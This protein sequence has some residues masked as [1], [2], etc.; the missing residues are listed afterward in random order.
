M[1]TP[2][3]ERA[4]RRRERRMAFPDRSR[5][6]PASRREPL[7]QQEPTTPPRP[8]VRIDPAGHAMIRIPHFRESE[9]RGWFPTDNG[10]WWRWGGEWW[11]FIEVP[12]PSQ[13]SWSWED[14]GQSTMERAELGLWLG[15]SSR[16]YW[17]G[18][19]PRVADEQC[20]RAKFHKLMERVVRIHARAGP[21]DLPP[22][23]APAQAL[24]KQSATRRHAVSK[25]H[26]V[27]QHAATVWEFLA[28]EIEDIDFLDEEWVFPEFSEPWQHAQALPLPWRAP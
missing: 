3:A 25:V 4:P 7:E 5:S 24:I 2:S 18:E 8:S 26:A 22:G 23:R 19:N 15:I 10:Y 17:L 12:T 20:L 6:P 14:A 1:R 9:R 13:I 11:L 21:R 28:D 16:R 27:A